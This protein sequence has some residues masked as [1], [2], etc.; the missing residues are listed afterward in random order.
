MNVGF[1]Y[2]PAL[3]F[4]TGTY[5]DIRFG[6]MNHGPLDLRG[7]TGWSGGGCRQAAGDGPVA[8]P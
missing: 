1:I 4:G 3:K 2:E 8:R 6:L 5:I 7:E